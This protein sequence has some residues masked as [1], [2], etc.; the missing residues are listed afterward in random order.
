MHPNTLHFATAKQSSSSC[1]SLVWLVCCK[2]C[3]L[4]NSASRAVLQGEWWVTDTSTNG[5]FINSAKIG[6]GNQ[7]VLKVDDRLGLSFAGPGQNNGE[8]MRSIE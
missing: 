1:G 7:A 3:Q 2:T 6:K 5:T 8:F 4:L